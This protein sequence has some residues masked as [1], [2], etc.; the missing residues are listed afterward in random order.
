MSRQ[1]T[2]TKSVADY[3]RERLLAKSLGVS[4]PSTPKPAVDEDEDDTSPRAGLGSSK[5]LLQI[6][7]SSLDNDAENRQLSKSVSPTILDAADTSTSTHHADTPQSDDTRKREKKQ[8]KKEKC[9]HSKDSYS[10]E[11]GDKTEKKDGKERKKKEKLKD[12]ASE[13]EAKAARKKARAERR[14]AEIDV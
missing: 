10:K 4:L 2:S 1:T 13:A 3:F 11:G 9:V 8:E 6:T 14:A 5:S 12:S 7:L